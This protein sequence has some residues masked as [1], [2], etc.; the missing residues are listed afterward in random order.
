[1]L[2]N[3]GVRSYAKLGTTSDK[4][5]HAIS[6]A[7][8]QMRL[9]HPDDLFDGS[10]LQPGNMHSLDKF[11]RWARE[12]LLELKIKMAVRRERTRQKLQE[13]LQEAKPADDDSGSEAK[14]AEAKSAAAKPCPYKNRLQ[15]PCPTAVWDKRLGRRGGQQ[16]LTFSPNACTRSL[17]A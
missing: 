4:R 12:D 16:E 14:P 13:K 17:G 15:Q 8:R 2:I 11:R 3:Q 7:T 5:W 9:S 6:T 10:R 1:M